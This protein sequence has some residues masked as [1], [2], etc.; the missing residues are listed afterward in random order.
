MSG[1]PAVASREEA[2]RVTESRRVGMTGTGEAVR[3]NLARG[4][5]FVIGDAGSGKLVA[6]RS[7]TTA[8]IPP[9]QETG[10]MSNDARQNPSNK[11]GRYSGGG[12]AGI[13]QVV[14]TEAEARRGL[15]PFRLDEDADPVRVFMLGAT[16]LI[17]ALVAGALLWRARQ[18]DDL[19]TRIRKRVGW[20]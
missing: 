2:E 17:G 12:P 16:A 10:A 14:P 19:P 3:G 4:T 8:H 11:S 13:S 5:V 18:P 7:L 6:V 9:A 15:Q 1:T 20:D